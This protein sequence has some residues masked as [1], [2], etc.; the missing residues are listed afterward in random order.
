[1]AFDQGSAPQLPFAPRT[2]DATYLN[3]LV[4]S[5]NTYFSMIDSP[6]GMNMTAITS[7]MI[8]TPYA[9]LTLGDGHNPDIKLPPFTF[10]RV[11]GPTNAF[12]LCGFN[13]SPQARN[14]GRQLIVFNPTTYNMTINNEDTD[15]VAENRIL[16]LTGANVTLTGTSVAS[17]IYS[18]KDLRWLVTSTQG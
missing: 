17:F 3:Q 16:T 7:N 8:R 13:S 1:M 12:D 15:S 5:L 9:E 11:T 6:S 18:V 14:N 10:L 4:R 2:Y